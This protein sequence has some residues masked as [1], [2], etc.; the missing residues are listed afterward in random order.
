MNDVIVKIKS[1]GKELIAS[2]VFLTHGGNE[3]EMEIGNRESPLLIVFQFITDN[4]NKEVRKATEARDQRTLVI[5]FY[6]YTDNRFTIKPWRIGSL[7]DKN[8]Y[9]VY[10][11]EPLAK[12]DLRTITYSFY[13]GEEVTNG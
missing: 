11:I 10:H 8:L 13:L 9:I 5:S 6:N 12:T 3:V 7:Y 2:G 4:E 1:D